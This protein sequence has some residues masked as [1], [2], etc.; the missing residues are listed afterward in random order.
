[1]ANEKGGVL[2]APPL[3]IL[4]TGLLGLFG[5]KNGGKYPQQLLESLQPVIDIFHL[6]GQTNEEHLLENLNAVAEGTQSTTLVVPENQFW[7]LHD[8]T[9]FAFANATEL[10]EFNCEYLL[11]GNAD[12]AVGPYELIDNVAGATSLGKIARM[13]RSREVILP[14]GTMITCHV[15]RLIG[16][17]AFSVSARIS[18]L[19]A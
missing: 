16:N 13:E 2:G 11:R 7:M 10:I 15:A 19:I 3:Q 6:Y 5:I 17:V 4:P 14:P 18:R 8:M 1:M 12:Y 9:V